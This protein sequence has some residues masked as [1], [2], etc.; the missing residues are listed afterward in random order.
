[1]QKSNKPY[2]VDEKKAKE[3]EAGMKKH[4]ESSPVI[5]AYRKIKE[6]LKKQ[7]EPSR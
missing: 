6:S 3:F 2:G 7:Q 4:A 5:N 1:M